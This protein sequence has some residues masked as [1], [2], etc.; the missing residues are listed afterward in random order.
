MPISDYIQKQA[1]GQSAVGKLLSNQQLHDRL[2]DI[3]PSGIIHFA[4][5]PSPPGPEEVRAKPPDGT[6]EIPHQMMFSLMVSTMYL[7]SSSVTYGPAGRHMP[8]L[9]IPSDTPFTYATLVS[10]VTTE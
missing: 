5:L 1:S 3:S 7:T 6:H 4:S 9:K 2:P 8:T 10:E